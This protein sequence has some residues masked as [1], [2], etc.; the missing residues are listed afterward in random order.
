MRLDHLQHPGLALTVGA[1][2]GLLL[3]RAPGA[4]NA[5]RAAQSGSAQGSP[6][7]ETRVLARPQGMHIRYGLAAQQEW[8]G[9]QSAGLALTSDTAWAPACFPSLEKVGFQLFLSKTKLAWRYL[10][11][12]VLA[13]PPEGWWARS[14][15]RIRTLCLCEL[16]LAR[17]SRFGRIHGR[18]C[19]SAALRQCNA[20]RGQQGLRSPARRGF[21]HV[22]GKQRCWL[23]SA[24][25]QFPL[26]VRDSRVGTLRDCTRAALTAAKAKQDPSHHRRTCSHLGLAACQQDA[27]F[28]QLGVF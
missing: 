27:M 25:W 14:C 3:C 4:E 12:S 15:L 16:F 5:H 1:R 23:H 17:L 19:C 13:A 22:S 28:M 2:E 24:A 8:R 6:A 7:L 20:A 18:P 10:P 11:A 21:R 9:R 26:Q